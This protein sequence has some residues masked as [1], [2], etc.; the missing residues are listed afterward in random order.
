MDEQSE[1]TPAQSEAVRRL[2]AGARDDEGIPDD[3]AARL[4]AVLG[5]LTAERSSAPVSR[6]A[7][8]IPLR[9]RWPKVLVA[10]AA[11]TAFGF[12]IVQL[13][14][15]SANDADSAG[16]GADSKAER[17]AATADDLASGPEQAPVVPQP[18]AS[19]GDSAAG[20][21]LQM[22]SQASLNMIGVQGLRQLNPGT[23]DRDLM[24]LTDATAAEGVN[25]PDYSYYDVRGARIS[26]GPF[27]T[28]V[29]GET[30]AASYRRHLALVLF[31]P[32]LDGVRL[33][34]IYDCE[35]RTPRRAVKTV[36]LQTGE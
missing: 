17:N 14:G 28:V 9:R 35:G 32:K 30:F 29:G 13:V 27:Y 20:L 25:G 34:E 8:V 26:C 5:D 24:K 23:L 18:A 31:H 6:K 2:L 4:E 7:E 15:N 16:A 12:G 19:P 22:L 3:V 33:V 21:R 10:A 11:V 1:L 36:T